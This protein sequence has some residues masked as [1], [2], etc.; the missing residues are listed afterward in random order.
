MYVG[1]NCCKRSKIHLLA[2]FLYTNISGIYIKL[3]CRCKLVFFLL[4]DEV[5]YDSC[6]D[7]TLIKFMYEKHRVT[8]TRNHT[9]KD[10]NYCGIHVGFAEA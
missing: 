7:E 6:K 10:R 2:I 1:D 3:R 4:K 9:K 5:G 8:W